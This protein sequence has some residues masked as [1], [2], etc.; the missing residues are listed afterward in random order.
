MQITGVRMG[1]TGAKNRGLLD[2]G[3]KPGKFFF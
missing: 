2:E 1:A 3:E